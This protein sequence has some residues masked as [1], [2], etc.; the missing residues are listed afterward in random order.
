M[1][2]ALAPA[3]L[4]LCA[5]ICACDRD[6]PRAGVDAGRPDTGPAPP[7]AGPA[8]ADPPPVL[9]A[10][11]GPMSGRSP[12]RLLT[13]YEY[14]NT[15]SD[16]LGFASSEARSFPPENS[17]NGFENNAWVHKASPSLVR[18]LLEAAERLG[19]RAASDVPDELRACAE[20]RTSPACTKGALALAERAYRRPLT[21]AEIEAWSPVPAEV[22]VEGFVA[23][24]LQSPAFLYRLELYE[25]GGDDRPRDGGMAGEDFE[26]IGP[27]ELATR[28]SYFLWATMP[29]RALLEAAAEGDL[30]TPARIKAEVER[31]SKDPRARG[32]I[33]ELARQWLGS[34]RVASRGKDA[35]VYPAW[36]PGLGEEYQA[37]LDAFL[38]YA[39]FERGTLEA[40]LT[41][42]EVF[43]TPALAA[44]LGRA[45]P[46]NSG[47]LWSE[48]MPED[49]RA[50]LLTQPGMLSAL[51]YPNQSSPI[52]RALFVRER[53][54]CQ[55]IPSPPPGDEIVPPDPDPTATTR[56]I[57]AIHTADTQ[58]AGCHTLIDP[59]GFGFESYDA[60]GRHRTSENGK[61]IDA[62][63]ALIASPDE[64]INGE[65]DGA[66]ELV[67]RLA[68]SRA[69]AR[70]TARHW[71][72][73][74]LGRGAD[75][76]DDASLEAVTDAFYDNGGSFADLAL[77]VALSD[78]FRFRKT[79]RAAERDAAERDAAKRAA[80]ETSP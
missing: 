46:E 61:P 43:L 4:I 53:L 58:C 65:F 57:F 18:Y 6:E 17:A 80:E 66:V 50:G 51:S 39:L 37:S 5:A 42:R 72:E 28:L 24:L 52:A 30:N 70:C 76:S 59:L 54:L 15:V 40:L 3:L 22:G 56:E 41:S 38:D 19:E 23:A 44:I 10:P 25:P 64:S 11:E 31:M 27:Y 33:R 12:M 2:P 79:R 60:L 71:F 55:H 68:R 67:G 7:D 48:T 78:A 14:D 36:R 77:A 34:D 74:A 62:S 1:R 49:E 13:R 47:G 32:A 73:Y 16:L 8:D 20:D 9:M 75:H 45:I 35:S 69:V 21:A 63:G 29:D 26:P